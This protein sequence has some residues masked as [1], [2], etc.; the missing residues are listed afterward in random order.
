LIE[1]TIPE[2]FGFSVVTILI[3][4]KRLAATKGSDEQFTGNVLGRLRE[5][6]DRYCVAGV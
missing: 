2:P 1:V 4:G 6:R 5:Q 3:S